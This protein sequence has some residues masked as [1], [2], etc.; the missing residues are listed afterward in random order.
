[1]SD[2]KLFAN[3]PKQTF[4]LVDGQRVA[5][6]KDGKLG[7]FT[8]RPCPGNGHNDTAG[9]WAFEMDDGE[10]VFLN[11]YI[12][13]SYPWRIPNRFRKLGPYELI[14][15]SIEAKKAEIAAEQWE[16]T[17]LQEDYDNALICDLLDMIVDK[18]V[19]SE[20]YDYVVERLQAMMAG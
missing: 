11:G 15:D 1:M 12:Y 13:D 5:R 2:Y 18:K 20:D 14:A 17:T 9:S 6:I 10:V 4:Q 19:K 8:W 7:T 3:H 16:P